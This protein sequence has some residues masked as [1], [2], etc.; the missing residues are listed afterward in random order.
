MLA[1]LKEDLL[2]EL[3]GEIYDESDAGPR[4]IDSIS[5]NEIL[6]E[7]ATELRVVEDFFAMELPGK[8][9]DTVS[10]WILNHTEYIPGEG[11]AFTIDNLEVTIIKASGRSIDQVNIRHPAGAPTSE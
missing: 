4:E 8:P 9:T 3:V 11:E 1:T 5:G 7:G 10:L 6:T 2:E